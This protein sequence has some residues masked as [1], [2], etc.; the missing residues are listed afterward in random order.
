MMPPPGRHP[1]HVAGLD[2]ACVAQA[3]AVRDR[4]DQ[5]VG[6]RLDAAMR[7]H[8]EAGHV[9]GGIVGA[10]VIEQQERIGKIQAAAG[11]A[12]LQPDARAFHDA[13]AAR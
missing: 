13:A 1:L 4:A 5:H 8:R 10:E 7:V 9:V 3:V 12:A 6:D 2:H 11:E